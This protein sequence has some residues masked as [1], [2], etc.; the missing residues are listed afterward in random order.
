MLTQLRPQLAPGSV[1]PRGAVGK[2]AAG[3]GLRMC[4]PRGR[5]GWMQAEGR[6]KRRETAVGVRGR[7]AWEGEEKPLSPGSS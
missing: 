3:N 5:K 2:G 7:K 6:D 1:L 4:D